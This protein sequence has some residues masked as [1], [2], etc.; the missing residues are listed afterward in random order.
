RVNAV[1]AAEKLD[2]V[3][4]RCLAITGVNGQHLRRLVVEVTGWTLGDEIE[5]GLAFGEGELLATLDM[6]IT[7]LIAIHLDHSLYRVIWEV[8]LI[9]AGMVFWSKY[10][11]I[12]GLGASDHHGTGRITSVLPGPVGGE[13]DPLIAIPVVQ[14][15][16]RVA[17]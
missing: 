8:S 17:L 2:L 10:P 3:S 1:E 13:G 11:F 12:H 15:A 14:D 6:P 9:Y 4:G 16:D 7:N 5:F